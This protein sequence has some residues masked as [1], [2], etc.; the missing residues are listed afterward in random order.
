MEI[1]GNQIKPIIM[2]N[3]PTV[4]VATPEVEQVNST[5]TKGV[6]SKDT[7]QKQAG[8]LQVAENKD[9][10]QKQAGNLQEA[11]SQIN[12]YVQN[13]QR[14]LQ[15]TV[16]EATGKDV[17]TVIDS[18]SKEVIRQLPSEEALA[19]ARRLAENK[20]AGIQLISTQV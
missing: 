13:L 4:K 7:D 1:T 12:D 16:D 18:E 11:V 17:V 20:D 3:T 2:E 6:E 19:L 8:N 9:T 14:D 10:D 15:F 5:I